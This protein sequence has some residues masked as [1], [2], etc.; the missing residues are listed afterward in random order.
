VGGGKRPES[1]VG[2]VGI[3]GDGAGLGSAPE[4]RL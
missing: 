4:D 3:R 2:L 1:E